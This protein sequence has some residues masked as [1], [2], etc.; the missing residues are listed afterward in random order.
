MSHPVLARTTAC[1]FDAYDTLFDTAAV[2]GDGSD[3]VGAA[4]CDM[5]SLDR[6]PP[7]PGI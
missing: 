3:A 7:L 1:V 2:A 5:Q 6:L 4:A